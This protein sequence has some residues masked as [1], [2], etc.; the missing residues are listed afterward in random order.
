MSG[1]CL[2]VIPNGS[3]SRLFCPECLEAADALPKSD[4]TV[5]CDVGLFH[6]YVCEGT[7]RGWLVGHKLCDANGRTRLVAH[8][9]R[10]WVSLDGE[11]RKALDGF[12]GLFALARG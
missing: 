10:L 6:V 12:L 3:G 4:Y 5:R 7:S 2:Y 1:L 8:V 11:G 9:R